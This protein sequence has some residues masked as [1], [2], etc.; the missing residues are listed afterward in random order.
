MYKDRL[1]LFW[2][3]TAFLTH[4]IAGRLRKVQSSNCNFTDLAILQVNP[5]NLNGHFNYFI[6]RKC[7]VL[8]VKPTKLDEM[9][10]SIDL[11]DFVQLE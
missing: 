8:V 10:F 7:Y 6:G 2:I 5:T 4:V 3:R 11:I 1:P 9:V